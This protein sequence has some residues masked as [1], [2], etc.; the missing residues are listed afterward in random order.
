M[1]LSGSFNFASYWNDLMRLLA[2]LTY[3][4]YCRL[5][6]TKIRRVEDKVEMLQDALEEQMAKS[7]EL[8]IA[9]AR[10]EDSASKEKVRYLSHYPL[11][12][13]H[14]TPH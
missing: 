5:V 10:A 11:L 13:R 7:S 9:K 3:H 8:E 6:N 4:N 12:L 1:S 14:M 2:C